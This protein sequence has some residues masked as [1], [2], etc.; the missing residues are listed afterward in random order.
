M[1][2]FTPPVAPQFR[3]TLFFGPEP[4]EDDPTTI[5][6][7]FNVKKRSWKAGIQIAV[8]LRRVALTAAWTRGALGA[9]LTQLV[10]V[11]PEEERAAAYTRGEEQCHVELARLKLQEALDLGLPQENQTL[12]ARDHEA[13]LERLSPADFATL[14]AQL[15]AELDLPDR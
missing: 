13:A 4:V 2:P 12:A 14:L 1:S 10:A 6:C 3:T 15:R 8:H 9:W 7:V 5:Q 11:L